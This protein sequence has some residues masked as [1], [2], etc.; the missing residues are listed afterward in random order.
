[1]NASLYP[2][3]QGKYSQGEY[4]VASGLQKDEF[5]EWIKRGEFR[6]FE[7]DRFM[8]HNASR[9]ASRNATYAFFLPYHPTKLALKRSMVNS[10]FHLLKRIEVWLYCLL[11]T[12]ARRGFC[13]FL[14]VTRQRNF[15]AVPSGILDFSAWLEKMVYNRQLFFVRISKR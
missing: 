14:L 6:N 1:M 11:G 9:N 4:T 15:N 8:I 7:R 2:L 10:R 3:T 13:R 5:I 12:Y